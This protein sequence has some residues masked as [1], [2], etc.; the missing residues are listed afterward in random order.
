MPNN[1]PVAEGEP[2]ESTFRDRPVLVLAPES[3]WP[4]SFG[5]AKA[6]LILKYY[7]AIKAFVA[8]HDKKEENGNDANP[9]AGAD[10]SGA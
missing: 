8:K 10:D 3:K 4:F 6:K 7:D 9:V 5:V 1:K 2:R